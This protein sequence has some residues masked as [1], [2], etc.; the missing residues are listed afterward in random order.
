MLLTP[1]FSITPPSSKINSDLPITP[2]P[3]IS[4]I[5]FEVNYEIKKELG[6]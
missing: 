6:K 5:K 1:T 3:I 2:A 4:D